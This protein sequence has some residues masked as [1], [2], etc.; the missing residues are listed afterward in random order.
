MGRS[1]AFVFSLFSHPYAC[2]D[3]TRGCLWAQLTYAACTTACDPNA[4]CTG[5]PTCGGCSSGFSGNGT[6]CTGMPELSWMYVLWHAL[7]AHTWYLASSAFQTKI[8]TVRSST[9]SGATAATPGISCAG[10][11]YQGAVCTPCANLG[12]GTVLSGTTNATCGDQ[13]SPCCNSPVFYIQSGTAAQLAAVQ[14]PFME[15]NLGVR[16]LWLA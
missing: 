5:G 4:L 16:G 13:G 1:D 15:F 2:V 3:T 6:V 12:A 9:A 10:L 7:T 11:A 8:A 14:Y